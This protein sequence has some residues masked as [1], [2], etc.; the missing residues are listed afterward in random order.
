M[1]LKK[2]GVTEFTY[3]QFALL[4]GEKLYTLAR[5]T[6]LSR[7][8]FSLF[9]EKGEITAHLAGT[10]H[11]NAHSKAD[12]PTVGDWV[13][14]RQSGKNARIEHLVARTTAISRKLPGDV[15]DEQ[16]LAANISTVFITMSMDSDFS[17][18]RLERYL[19][20]V[21]R[22]GAK[23]VILLSKSDTTNEQELYKKLV[24]PI[25]FNTPF[26]TIS[27]KEPEQTLTLLNSYIPAEETAVFIGSSGVG[28]STLINLLMHQEAQKTASVN[29]AS[30][31]GRHTT[32]TRDLLML[33]TGGMVID[34]PGLRELQLWLDEDDKMLAFPDIIELSK[35]CK[36]NDCTH[37]SEPHCAVVSAVEEGTLDEER[38]RRYITLKEEITQLNRERKERHQRRKK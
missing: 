26:H 14:I 11:K 35:L 29:D 15:S 32:V 18:P 13:A 37:I 5:V 17:I 19:T 22:S 20:I 10:L 3:K 28:K 33:S 21:H 30:G 34:T 4:N 24:T 25:A 31:R 38:Y 1:N 36:F 2:Y 6:A 16:V 9:T 8:T 7:K 27:S 12:I 23:A